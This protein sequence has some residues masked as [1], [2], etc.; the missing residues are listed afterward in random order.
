MI[1]YDMSRLKG[2]SKNTIAGSAS[3]RNFLKGL[4]MAPALPLLEAG[5]HTNGVATSS[6]P[7]PGVFQPFTEAHVP[8]EPYEWLV[9]KRYSLY[10]CHRDD[11]VKHF[12]DDKLEPPHTGNLFNADS[13]MLFGIADSQ[14]IGMIWPDG[15]MGFEGAPGFA[16]WIFTDDSPCSIRFLPNNPVLLKQYLVKNYL[17]FIATKW[18]YQSVTRS[19]KAVVGAVA[20]N[21][22]IL[23]TLNLNSTTEKTFQLANAATL[24]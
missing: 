6:K 21:G 2:K 10:M 23:Y 19:A 3:R 17:P 1:S 14:Y 18:S 15:S 22:R 16:E 24:H 7:A 12:V 5:A 13:R 11:Y 4:G 20:Y 8:D 9:P